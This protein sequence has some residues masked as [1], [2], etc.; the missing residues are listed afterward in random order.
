MS[1]SIYLIIFE[2]SQLSGIVRKK[3]A[4]RHFVIVVVACGV[5]YYKL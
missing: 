4:I 2:L 1:G 5:I 3:G